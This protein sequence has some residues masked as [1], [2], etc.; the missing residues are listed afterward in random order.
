MRLNTTIDCSF[1]LGLSDTDQNHNWFQDVRLHHP[2]LSLNDVKIFVHQFC[3]KEINNVKIS[4]S[5]TTDYQ[6]L[7]KKQMKILKRIESHYNV[8][9]TGDQIEPLKIIVMRTAETS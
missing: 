5:K 7:N 4:Y 1:G 3:N 9:I 2:D 6:T 8:I